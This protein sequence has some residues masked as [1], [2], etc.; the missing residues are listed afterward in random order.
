MTDGGSSTYGADAVGGVINFITRRKFDGLQLGVRHGIADDYGSTDVNRTVKRI[1]GIKAWP[2]LALLQI[3]ADDHALEE[4][5]LAV[6]IPDDLQQRHL[7]QRRNREELVGLVC[8]IDVDPLERN[9]L[10]A[11]NDGRALDEGAQRVADER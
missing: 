1:E 8:K 6:T 11:Q 5:V 3:L 7:S 4:N 9:V 2:R 10:L